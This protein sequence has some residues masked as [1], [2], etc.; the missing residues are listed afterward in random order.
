MRAALDTFETAIQRVRSLHALHAALSAQVTGVIDLSDILRAEIVLAVSAF[1]FFI[2]EL[3]R[4]GMLECHT[5]K[6]SKTDAFNR[7]QLPM[8][9]AATMSDATLDAEIRAKHAYLTFQQ[10]DRIADAI[11]LFSGVELW[12]DVASEC[13]MEPKE[14]KNAFSLVIDR[15][16][17]IAHEADLDPSYLGQRWPIDRAQVDYTCN[18]IEKVGRAIF[19]VVA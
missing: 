19:R 7:F 9:V 13:R 17:K 6:R 11:R 1:D 8:Y 16:N 10:P 14:L 3:T 2:H 12:N 15:R 18:L 5:G 4:L